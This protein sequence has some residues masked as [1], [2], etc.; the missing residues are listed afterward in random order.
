MTEAGRYTAHTPRS[1]SSRLV[2]ILAAATTRLFAAGAAERADSGIR[3]PGLSVRQE[4]LLREF[5]EA[6]PEGYAGGVWMLESWTLDP[7]AG[8]VAMPSGPGNAAAHFRRL[9][10]LFPAE[11]DLLDGDGETAGVGELLGAAGCGECRLV[12]E[13]YP[14][15]DN[16]NAKTP[17]FVVLRSY[18]GALLA[19]AAKKERAGELETAN[20]MYEAGIV[21]GVHLA[22][23]RSN[24]L[25]SMT[26]LIFQLRSVRA[27]E[28]FLQRSG[29]H[30]R[31]ESARKVRGELTELLRFFYWKANYALGLF[32]DFLSLPTVVEV[33]LYDADPAWRALAAT[34]LA[35]YRHGAPGKDGTL[36]RSVRWQRV[37][38]QALETMSANEPDSVVRSLAAWSVA[39]LV[40]EGAG[41]RRVL[42][43]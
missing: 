37:A 21:C 28:A 5:R 19:F 8:L 35:A 33:A 27:Y 32:E 29:R 16:A 36:V 41:Q 42:G 11:K 22:R 25:V 38:R 14:P 1:R 17:D 20:I 34:R 31:A 24:T 13:F 2:L 23:D 43:K 15:F 10:D 39:R 3:M 30:E 26:G 6:A 18:L 7:A 12:P 40:P 9:E 4:G